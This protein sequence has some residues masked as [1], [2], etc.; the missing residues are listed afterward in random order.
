MRSFALALAVCAPLIA[1]DHP[2][3][4]LQSMLSRIFNST[5]FSGGG[6]GGRRGGGGTRWIE[7]GNA[8][9]A[10]EA[11]EI[12]RYDPASG[13]RDV[14]VSAA[15]LT[16]K[17]T[18]KPLPIADFAWSADG[19]KLLVSTNPHRVL[20]RKP[21]AEYWVL[22]RPTGAWRKLG[23]DDGDNLLFA[24]LSPDGNAAAYVRGTNLFVED[25]ATG[26][27]TAADQRWH[28]PHPQ[29]RL[30]LGLRR[31]VR[32]GR[33]LSLES[34]RAADRLLAVRPAQRARILA[35]QLHRRAVSR[36]FQVR[37]PEGRP[38]QLGRPG[39]GSQRQGRTDPLD[40]GAGRSAQYLYPAHGMGGPGRTHSGASEP[41]A[42][43]ARR[44]A[45]QC[46]DRRRAHHVSRSG[47]R[48]GGGQ[49]PSPLGG[50]RQ[51]PAL[52]QRA[53]WL[54]ARLHRVARRRHA[55]G[56]QGS[57]RRDL[58]CGRRRAGGWLYYIASPD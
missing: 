56:D 37:V 47:R 29:R 34:R 21:A 1:Q 58:D 14:L 44:P 24:K 52:D 18:G 10:I 9:A 15:Q 7:G 27:I 22:D 57:W 19:K 6:R 38:D 33:R 46:R 2:T 54:A 26:A 39:G 4:K 41:P 32:P 5:E 53:R 13:K 40:Q 12:V 23:G 36:N 3:E 30:R 51:A 11:G 48:L 55:P 16:P 20:I 17:Q 31:R 42:E 28:R 35:G 25:L 49:R 43:H 8:Y 45:G 50:E